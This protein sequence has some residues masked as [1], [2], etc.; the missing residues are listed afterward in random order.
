[1]FNAE[2]HLS[3]TVRHLSQQVANAIYEV[4]AGRNPLIGPFAAI[5]NCP[6]KNLWV[7]VDYLQILAKGF[8]SMSTPNVKVGRGVPKRSKIFAKTSSWKVV[9]TCIQLSQ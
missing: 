4:D 9:E 1:M 6:D 7:A 5:H 3:P 8:K 2:F